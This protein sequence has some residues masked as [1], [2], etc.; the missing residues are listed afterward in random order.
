MN[1]KRARAFAL[2]AVIVATA[3]VSVFGFFFFRDNFSTHYPIKV[4]SAKTF[5]SGEIPYW[6]F[7]DGG[8][9]PL[10]GN[11]NTLTF[12]P[13][14]FLYLLLP[15]HVAFNLH[16]LLHL[17]A[18]WFA[19]RALSRSPYAAWM[20]VL[21]GAAISA[22]A[23]YNLIVAIAV[24]PFAFWAAERRNLFLLGSA[25]GLLALAGE[26]VMILSA[27]I[28]VAILWPSW[29]LFPAAVI[30]LVIALPQLIAYGEIASE[31]ERAR[32]F[33]AQTVLNASLEPKRI[34]EIVAGPW[35]HVDAP[36]LFLSLFIGIVAV[37][38]LFQRSRYVAIALVSLFFALGRFNPLV[39]VIVE[40]SPRMRVARFPEKF[41]IVLTVAIV[42]LAAKYLVKREWLWITLVPLALSA[43]LTTPIDLFGP[44]DVESVQS[45]RVFA[46]PSPGGQEPVR[47]DYRARAQH[48]EPA[49]GAVA[50]LRYAC[51]RSPDGMFSLASR[52]VAEGVQFTHNAKW[53]RIAGC[54]N[55]PHSLPHAMIVPSIVGATEVVRAVEAQSF[56]EHAAAVG[57][58]RF[59]GFR[60]PPDAKI[61]SATDVDIRVTTPAPA[62]LFVNETYFRAWDAGGYETFPLD[63]DRL[64]ILVPAGDHTIHLQFG[65]HHTAVALT[66][67]LSL[68]V[69]VVAAAA[70]RVE[71]LN[72]RAGEVERTADEDRLV[73]RA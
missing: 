11:P 7:Y 23:F 45:I 31:V 61:V 54:A 4:V 72:R 39:R 59:N 5:R 37:P 10:A 46:P 51:D 60:S 35:L 33:S 42:V 3:L 63:V 15:P 16:F 48:L 26:P 69:L 43:V 71:V 27:A 53:L 62:I 65:R 44:Y 64:G 2:I 40:A 12:Y 24:I 30:S 21:S 18:A 70:L 9:Q 55:V 6:N 58:V 29:R 49:F 56:D 67:A 20:Y 66:W 57:P 25:F 36:H 73:A 28:G 1:P 52:V 19:M 47:S 34:L 41:A 8:G 17:I 68:L 22:T 38:A 14:N 13:D 32:G 50:G